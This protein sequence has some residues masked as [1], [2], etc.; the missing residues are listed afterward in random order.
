MFETVARYAIRKPI[1]LAAIVVGLFVVALSYLSYKGWLDVKWLPIENTAKSTLKDV[2]DQVIHA[3]PRLSLNNGPVGL[4]ISFNST[5]EV[6]QIL[7]Y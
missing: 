4:P 5:R 2:T 3:F 1:K 6:A 7:L